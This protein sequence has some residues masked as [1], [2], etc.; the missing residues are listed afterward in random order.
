MWDEETDE[1]ITTINPGKL[2]QKV[3]MQI[4]IKCEDNWI[5]RRKKQ[6][7]PIKQEAQ[8][9]SIKQNIPDNPSTSKESPG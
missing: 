3:K 7:Y 5:L 9:P 8:R 6:Y 1:E 2:G 4:P